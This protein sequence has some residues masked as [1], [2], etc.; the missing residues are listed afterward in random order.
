MIAL[1]CLMLGMIE[2][3][4]PYPTSRTGRGGRE[5]ISAFLH[6][7]KVE[8]SDLKHE[9]HNHEAEI[10]MFEDRLT[11]QETSFETLRQQLIEDVECKQEATQANQIQLATK[12]E[13]LD[14]LVKNLESMIKGIAADLRQMKTTTNESIGTFGQYKQKMSELEN[15]LDT[16]HEH[17][18]NLENAVNALVEIM[19]TQETKKAMMTQSS[20]ESKNYKVQ[21]GDTLRKI[22]KAKKVSVKALKEANQLNNDEDC[23]LIGQIL[24]I[25]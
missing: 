24:K 21:P 7:I 3:A 6:Q 5:E 20:E 11:N 19:K 10:R 23:I 25:P 16:H 14:F 2:A 9:M 15:R 22:A 1:C 17:M 4:T 13:S 8:I 18:Q 12:V